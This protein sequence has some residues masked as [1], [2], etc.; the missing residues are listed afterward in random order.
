MT[1]GRGPGGGDLSG[2][3]RSTACP[4]RNR[5]PRQ[6][7]P[8]EWVSDSLPADDVSMWCPVEASRRTLTSN[9]VDGT[10]VVVLRLN[11]LVC[12]PLAARHWKQP[13]KGVTVAVTGP[14]AGRGLGAGQRLALTT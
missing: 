11:L 2:C 14:L 12:V 1:G 8:P 13:L 4:G 3:V 7:T 9:R 6:L 10:L 5:T